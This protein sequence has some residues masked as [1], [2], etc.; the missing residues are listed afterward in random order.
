M[1]FLII[2]K[3]KGSPVSARVQ[4]G[5]MVVGLVLIACVFLVTLYYDVSRIEFVKSLMSRL[6]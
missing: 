2:E 5:A 1:V 4:T 6:F 3:I